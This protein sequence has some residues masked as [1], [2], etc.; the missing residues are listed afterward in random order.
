M[1]KG[2]VLAL[3]ITGIVAFGCKGGDSSDGTP[4]VSGK[5]EVKNMPEG[6]SPPGDRRPT[7]AEN[8][9]TNESDARG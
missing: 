3:L 6:T 7:P 4:K 2:L 1:K 9:K 5:V 8:G